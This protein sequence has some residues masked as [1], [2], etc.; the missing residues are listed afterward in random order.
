M[1]S[2]D[3]VESYLP[4]LVTFGAPPLL[5]VFGGAAS[6]PL[7]PLRLEELWPHP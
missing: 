6:S 5:F 3:G 1:V 4:L 7:P 2:M